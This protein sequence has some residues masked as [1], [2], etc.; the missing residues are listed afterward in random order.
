[1]KKTK[2]VTTLGPAV[3]TYDQIKKIVD[4]GADVFRLNFSHG[5][6]DWH[7][8][9]IENI[10]R[11]EK[12]LERNFPI[13]LDT[14]GPEIRTADIPCPRELENGQEI[15]FTV[16]QEEFSHKEMIGVNYADFISDVSVGDEVLVDSGVMKVKVTKIDGSHVFCDVLAGGTLGSRRHINL[17]GKHVSLEP[18]TDKDWKD[19]EFGISQGV[20]YIA[21]SFVRE[22]SDVQLI[23]DFL[24]KKSAENIEII[25]KIE[26]AEA[27]ANIDEILKIAD[28]VMVARGDLGAELPFSEVPRIQREI[29]LAAQKQKK[30]VIVATQMLES[31]IENP[32]PTRAEVTD[33]SNAVFQRA[34]ATM[35]SGETA[36]GEHP[37]KAVSTMA[38]IL[39]ESEKNFVPTSFV[40]DIGVNSA[41]EALTKVGAQLVEE[42]SDITAIFVLTQ[43]GQT[44]RYISSFRPRRDIFAFTD[45]KNTARKIKLLWGTRAFLVDFDTEN[46]EVTIEDAKRIFLEKFPDKKGSKFL[47]LSGSLVNDKFVPMVQVREL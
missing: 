34:D 12:D 36:S 42:L 11:L 32:I 7:K 1:M 40:R 13:I 28:A 22:A 15:V 4:A 39:T 47:L 16:N 43:S 14:K 25:A 31:M 33:V 46:P 29:I 2:I 35:L 9:L 41:A 10:R 18:V 24:K 17:P 30:P 23:K 38:E 21:Q 20:D 27:A 8:E 5:A 3:K 6:H 19:I 26:T 45:D 44:A 37:L